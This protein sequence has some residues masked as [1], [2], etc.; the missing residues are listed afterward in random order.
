MLCYS[1]EGNRNIRSEIGVLLP[2]YCEAQNIEKLVDEIEGLDM[3]VSILVIDDSSPDGTAR[4]VRELEKKYDNILLSVRPGKGGLGTAI[5]DGFRVFLSLPSP[6]EYIVTMDADFSHNPMD[7]P[8]AILAAKQGKGLAI[9]S[10]YCGKGGVMNWSPLRMII[11]R[12]AN[13]VASVSVRARIRDYTSGL[14]CYSTKL[15]RK[16]LPDL[17]SQ[18]YEIQIETIRQARR[19][20]FDV[21]EFPMVFI[22]RKKGKSKLS[23]NEIIEFI[24]YMMKVSLGSK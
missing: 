4:I 22:N 8:R 11:S 24:S 15:V 2:T 10:R 13:I 17:H 21:R 19:R 20:G 18:T 3:D 9:G 12:V 14:R 16:I 23:Q 6:P 1:L 5:T 7:V